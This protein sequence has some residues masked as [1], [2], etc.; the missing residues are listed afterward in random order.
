MRNKKVV[1]MLGML[2]LIFSS[3]AVSALRNP[4]RGVTGKLGGLT[5]WGV[6][7]V[8]AL[9][10]AAVLY[11][12]LNLIPYIKPGSKPGHIV[13][14]AVVIIFAVMFAI[15]IGDKFIW[16]AEAFKGGLD[17][18]FRDTYTRD[19]E[20]FNGILHPK[21]IWKFIGM[22]LIISWLF[23]TFL[24]VGQTKQYIDIALAIIISANAVHGGM[25]LISVIHLGQAIA[26]LILTVQFSKTFEG[27]PGG[28][29]VRW[30]A[31][32]AV[33]GILVGW[34]SS[35]VFPN[36]PFLWGGEEKA[37]SEVAEEAKEGWSWGK[38]AVLVIALILAAGSSGF[39]G[40]L[41][42]SLGGKI[43]E[44]RKRG[45]NKTQSI[46]PTDEPK[47]EEEVGS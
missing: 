24:K 20:T 18:L 21:H 39:T 31:A 11:F 19:G 16:S 7:A 35:I 8:N 45:T 15:Q 38:A 43:K 27:L 44:T 36:I 40:E 32:I 5:G 29:W 4:F 42:K 1:L 30:I 6:V 12:V 13:M 28:N 46:E 14:A 26:I 33:A 10:I 22:S 34:I 17:Y 2:F 37:I 9:I 3:M 41:I 25:E 23:I 47:S